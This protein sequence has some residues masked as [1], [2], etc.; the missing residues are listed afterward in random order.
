MVDAEILA[1]L[2]RVACKVARRVGLRIC[3]PA[4]VAARIFSGNRLDSGE[5]RWSQHF[6]GKMSF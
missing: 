1:A 6:G 5:I 4:V 2:I 3:N